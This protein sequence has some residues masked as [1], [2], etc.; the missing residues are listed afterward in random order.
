MNKLAFAALALALV[1]SAVAD[2]TSTATHDSIT[3]EI[4]TIDR[5]ESAAVLASDIDALA[6]YWAE[7]LTVNSPGNR[8]VRGR[9]AVFELV[10][11]GILD[12]AAFDREVEA[13]LPHGDTVIVMGV[14]T[15]QPRGKAPFAGQT[16]RRRCTNI[17]MKRRG[18]WQ[19][20]ARHASIIP[21]N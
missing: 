16:L 18:Q 17:W 6:G 5:A 3:E 12:Y 7:D 15:V 13:V 21:P 11:S 1:T 10:R 20:T 9:D 2:T 8:V 19:L 4:R 14:E